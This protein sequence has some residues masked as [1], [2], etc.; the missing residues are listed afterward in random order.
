MK[1][2]KEIYQD[3]AMLLRFITTYHALRYEQ[4][5][6]IFSKN[7]NSIKTLINTLVK[8]GRI[9]HDKE[10]GLLCDSL[11][12]AQ[13]PD[14]GLI[15]SF[16]VLLD[17]KKAIVYHTSGEFPVKIN[18]FS[19]DDRYEI[20]YI[21]LEQ[22]ILISHVMES[23]PSNDAQRLVVLESQNQASKI[24]IEG[25]AAYCLVDDTGIVSFYQR[26]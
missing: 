8:Q 20:L 5:I 1:T 19:Q 9:I 13:N 21:G 17:F 25:V 6:R 16:W 2:R 3:G 26:K 11:E 15:A 12:A 24:S 10:K 23:I 14:Y 22:E 7:E 18:F 4:V